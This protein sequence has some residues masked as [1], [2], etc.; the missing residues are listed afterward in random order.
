MAKKEA[1]LM[2]SILIVE[3]SLSTISE[4]IMRSLAARGHSVCVAGDGLEALRA[5]RV[6]EP[7]LALLDARLPH[8]DGIQLCM[9][10]RRLKKYAS[11]PIVI[12][13]ATSSPVDTQR[14]LN[15]GASVCLVKPVHDSTL[16]ATIEE[17]LARSYIEASRGR[18]RPRSV[19]TSGEDVRPSP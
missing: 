19:A 6:F 4:T 12:L 1:E 17:Q 18:A 7:D 10:I 8:I 3:D 15:A 2:A 14:A 9:V 11:L 5:L 13:S 16:L